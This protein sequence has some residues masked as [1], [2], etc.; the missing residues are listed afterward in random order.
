MKFVVEGKIKGKARPRWS[1]KAYC[2]N[3]IC[4]SKEHERR[5]IKNYASSMRYYQQRNQT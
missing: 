5:Q 1:S 4:N 3:A 2:H